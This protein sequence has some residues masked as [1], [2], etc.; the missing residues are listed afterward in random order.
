MHWAA[1]SR[2]RAAFLPA[3]SCRYW[4]ATRYRWLPEESR[5]ERRLRLRRH[6][7][8]FAVR[9]PLAPHLPGVWPGRAA[10]PPTFNVNPALAGIP[11]EC[12][13]AAS[14]APGEFNAAKQHDKWEAKSGGVTPDS[15]A[16]M[17]GRISLG[18]CT[19]GTKFGLQFREPNSWVIFVCLYR[20][21]DDGRKKE[22]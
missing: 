10:F 8:F 15:G 13:D 6:A 14:V 2:C 5:W 18:A 20:R 19:T 22:S 17:A 1:S 12:A 9:N 11:P 21:E 3:R 4:V 16:R 7:R